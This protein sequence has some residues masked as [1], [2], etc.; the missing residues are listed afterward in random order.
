MNEFGRPIFIVGLPRS[1]TKL[2][3]ALVNNHPA[4]FIPAYETECLPWLVQHTPATGWQGDNGFARLWQ[5]ISHLPFFDYLKNDGIQV[6]ADGWKA[7][8][9]SRDAAGVFDG[10]MRAVA[11]AQGIT[12]WQRWGDKSPSHIGHVELI[13]QQ[14]PG[15]RIIHIVRDV[16]DVAASS[17]K[18]WGKHTVRTAQRWRDQVVKVRASQVHQA[19]PLLEVSF[20]NLVHNPGSVMREVMAFIGLPFDKALLTL[21]DGVEDL[22]SAKGARNI[23]SQAAGNYHQALTPSETEAVERVACDAMAIYGYACDIWQGE[24]KALPAWRMNLLRYRDAMQLVRHRMHTQ[25]VSGAISF[26]WRYSR[27]S[28]NRITV[29]PV[30]MLGTG[31]STRG[32]I[33][34]VVRAYRDSGFLCAEQVHYLPTHGDGSRLYKGVLAGS[35]GIRLCY[36]LLRYPYRLVHVHLSSGSSFWRK[37][38]LLGIVRVFRKPYVL[39][40]HGSEFREFHEVCKASQQKV[41][42]QVF[43][44]AAAIVVLSGSWQRWV[45]SISNNPRITVIPNAVSVPDAISSRPARQLL[46]LGRLGERKGVYTLLDAVARLKAVFPDMHLVCAGDGEVDAVRRRVE[47]LGLQAQVSVPGWVDSD[48]RAHLLQRS[49]VFVLPS[50]NEGLPMAILEAM[51]AGL[52]VVSTPVGG[53][54]DAV[55]DGVTGTLVPPGDLDALVS[56]LKHLLE[57]PELVAQWGDAGRERIRQQFSPAAS[58]SRMRALWQQVAS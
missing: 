3:R 14:F 38:M 32:G 42:R 37:C 2:L 26:Y 16:R 52:A 23:L 46:F 39:H 6:T 57:T 44:Q 19:L 18:A 7:H 41:V 10:L 1:G 55:L 13:A 25:G 28:G 11:D 20:E 9:Q 4:I 8:C 47:A 43:D 58:E 54:P 33:A 22:G 51:A 24:R 5:S 15:A 50:H 12:G 48:E 31:F 27:Y 35:A 40:L 45:Q 49:S 29:C 56:A 36:R 21:P 30:L 17:R 34:S 53:I